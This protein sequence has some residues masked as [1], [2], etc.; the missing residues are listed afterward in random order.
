M[1]KRKQVP[2]N[3]ALPTSLRALM[4]AASEYEFRRRS[5]SVACDAGARDHLAWTVDAASCLDAVDK[6]RS[7]LTD[8]ATKWARDPKGTPR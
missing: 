6:A 4:V 1:A 3:P 5:L 2:P 8:A 7:D